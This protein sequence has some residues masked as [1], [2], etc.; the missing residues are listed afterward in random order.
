MQHAVQHPL[1]EHL[2]LVRLDTEAE[3]KLHTTASI[4]VERRKLDGCP[5]PSLVCLDSGKQMKALSSS[6]ATSCA[7]GLAMPRAVSSFV[8]YRN[9]EAPQ[10]KNPENSFTP[11]AVVKP[12]NSQ[13]HQSANKTASKLASLSKWKTSIEGDAQ[14]LLNALHRL[15]SVHPLVRSTLSSQQSSATLL[16]IFSTHDLAQ[17]LYLLL[18]EK[19]RFN[20]YLESQMTD[21]EIEREIFQIELTN[22]LIGRLRSRRPENYRIVRRV[23]GVLESEA[24]F[25]VFH[26]KNGQTGRYRQ[27]ADVIYGL[28]EWNEGKP[29]RDS[30]T[31]TDLIAHLP[32]RV[33]NL[34][35]VGCRGEAQVIVTNQELTELMVEIL[36]AI[37]SPAPLRVLRQLALTKLPVYDAEIGSLE[38]EVNE[39]S[40]QRRYAAALVSTDSTPEQ[41]ALAGE[42][43]RQARHIANAFLDG[44]LHSTRSNWLRT[45]RLW[46]VLWHC[47]FDPAEPSQL[48]IADLVGISDSSVSDYRRKLETELRKLELTADQV[49][50]FTEELRE[51][52][53]W[54]LSLPGPSFSVPLEAKAE[55][56]DNPLLSFEYQAVPHSRP[57]L[58]TMQAA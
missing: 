32:M 35:R 24:R 13:I 1:P 51:Q 53:Q 45:E 25:K 16:P 43:E 42:T 9:P 50:H 36:R 54:R 17:D 5:D 52:L 19:G 39:E 3:H 28:H 15:V 31:F 33:R 44:L 21:A 11:K 56:L 2:L 46:R 23:S 48:L 34:R 27:A 40:H 7:A 49:R 29:M 26:K 10:E 20:H 6:R 18:L 58:E 14:A 37:D 30:G 41:L 12:L 22:F 4:R 57:R 55:T 38:D 8:V 47:F